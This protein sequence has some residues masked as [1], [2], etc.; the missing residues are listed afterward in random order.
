MTDGITDATATA[1]P[2]AEPVAQPTPLV[3]SEGILSESWRESLPEDIRSEKVFDRVKDF[4]GAMRS[5]ASAERMIGTEKIP[6]PSDSSGDDEWGA[7]W[8]AGGR[9]GTAEEYAVV[10][11]EALPEQYWSEDLS[12]N[13]MD[14]AHKIGL[15]KKQVD[16]LSEFQSGNT[17]QQ[18]Q[19]Q[20]N[21]IDVANQELI[22]GL[23]KEWGNAYDQKLHIGNKALEK[24][25]VGNEELRER[26]AQKFGKDPDFIKVM[27]NLGALFTESSPPT[28]NTNVQ[29]PNQLQEKINDLMVSEAYNNRS[30]PNHQ[31]TLDKLKLL[32][33]EKNAG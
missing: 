27:S 28:I 18:L 23:N 7:Y 13:F 6:K 25:A 33:K 31:I 16:A 20:T 1:E 12:K 26:V 3:N 2:T 21:A 19:D 9:P 8:D 30:H 4:N 29:T 32:Y 10:R 5:L 24:G 14:L 11:P 17:M 22:D 15:S